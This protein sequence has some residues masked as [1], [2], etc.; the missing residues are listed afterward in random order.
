MSE[1]ATTIALE[2]LQTLPRFVLVA[3]ANGQIDLNDLAHRELANQ[4]ADL[5]GQWAGF[6]RAEEIYTQASQQRGVATP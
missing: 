5:S 2:Y 3:A 6:K 1:L 4:G